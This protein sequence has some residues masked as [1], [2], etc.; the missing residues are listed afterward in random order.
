MRAEI[1]YG[2]DNTT[3]TAA[4][5]AAAIEGVIRARIGNV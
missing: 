2:A 4:V 5:A 3:S 1:Q